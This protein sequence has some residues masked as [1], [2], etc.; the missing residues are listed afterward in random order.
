MPE[1]ES[2]G[3]KKGC[4]FAHPRRQTEQR[5]RRHH[6]G[7]RK[8]RNAGRIDLRF[9]PAAPPGH[10]DR[11][12]EVAPV[13]PPCH[14]EEGATG[15]GGIEVGNGEQ[16]RHRLCRELFHAG[17]RLDFAGF[18]S[19]VFAPRPKTFWPARPKSSPSERQ[20]SARSGSCRSAL[21][22]RPSPRVRPQ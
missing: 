20:I 16:D 11:W 13:Q 3:C 8:K 17:S 10:T 4:G 15:A 1:G 5:T 19:R 9:E 22:S 6:E 12:S 7:R 21:S 18:A 14:F 2:P